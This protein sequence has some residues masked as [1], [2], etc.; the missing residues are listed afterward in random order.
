MITLCPTCA[1]REKREAEKTLLKNIFCPLCGE[2]FLT[3]GHQRASAVMCL[4][5]VGAVKDRM[6]QAQKSLSR[7]MT[8]K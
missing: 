8:C 1:G 2:K 7:G 4:I 5:E 3:C 6:Y